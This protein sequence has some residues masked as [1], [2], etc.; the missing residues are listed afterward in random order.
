MNESPRPV[1]MVSSLTEKGAE[2]T[3]QALDLGALDYI[4]KGDEGNVLGV[5]HIRSTLCSKVRALARRDRPAPLP[6]TPRP[7]AAAVQRLGP[8]RFVAVGASTGGPPALQKIFSGFSPDFQAPVVVVQ[9][10]PK[11]FTGSF[12]RRLDGVGPLRVKEAETGDRLEPG[13]GFV[14]PGGSHLTVRAVGPRLTLQVTDR[15]ADT[16]HKPSVDVTFRSI[17]EAA[18]RLTLGVMLT[19]MGSDGVEGVRSLK[20]TGGHTIAQD[21][22]TCV[23]YG[24]PRAVV[25]AGMADAV[26][27]IERMVQAIEGAVE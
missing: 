10:M 26:L 1:L 23:V 27:P 9:H 25:E 15:P 12:A 16:L 13:M 7:T 18:G 20:A 2:V 21:A 17:A 4:P 3:L 5:V 14:A 6:P 24:M 11:A 8:A 19:G 22:E